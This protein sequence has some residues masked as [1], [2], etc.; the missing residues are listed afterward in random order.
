MKVNK[1]GRKRVRF[2]EARSRIPP[3]PPHEIR[4]VTASTRLFRIKLL[5]LAL[6]SEDVAEVALLSV[7]TEPD[8][9]EPVDSLQCCLRLTQQNSNTTF[10]RRRRVPQVATAI[11]T[12]R[13]VSPT[14]PDSEA[15]EVE[16]NGPVCKQNKKV[17]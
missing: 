15:V 12:D 1:I 9:V 13:G 11:I 8:P 4:E 3:P 2:E 7:V 17:T 16:A 10:N 6:P 5:H 14:P